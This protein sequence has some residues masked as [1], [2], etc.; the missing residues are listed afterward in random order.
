[1]LRPRLIPLLLLEEERLVKTK[2]F[3][4]SVYIGDPINTV[5][6][7]N[8]KEVDEL[9]IVDYL[10]TS[11]KREIQFNLIKEIVGESFMPITYGGGVSTLLSMEKLFFLGIEKISM[12]TQALINPNFVQ[13]AAEE[14]GSQAIIV[15]I[16]LKKDFFGNY[17]IKSR[18]FPNQKYDTAYIK[19]FVDYGAG[20]I[21]INFIDRDGTFKGLD[22][23]IITELASEIDVPLIFSGGLNSLE[24]FKNAIDNGSSAV[25]AGSFLVFRGKNQGVLLSYPKINYDL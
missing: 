15:S 4:N 25:A 17:Y 19:K 9:M 8:E 2:K 24:D 10:C 7:F 16:D 1:M 20:E 21:Q 18:N 22:H 5:K 6:I 11:K 13:K 23:K 12:Q 14:F 3:S